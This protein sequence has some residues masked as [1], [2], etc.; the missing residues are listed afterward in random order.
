LVRWV[1]IAA[2]VAA[3][4]FAYIK[5]YKKSHG[6]NKLYLNTINSILIAAAVL[7]LCIALLFAKT[8]IDY[9][10]RY[11]TIGFPL[12]VLLWLLLNVYTN[13][14][15]IIIAATFVSFYILILAFNYK[16]P[17]ND[18][19][20]R[21]LAAYVSRIEKPNEPILFYPKVLALPFKYYYNGKNVIGPLPDEI[22]FDTTYLSKIQDTVQLQRAIDKA[23]TSSGSYILITNRNDSRFENEA[24]VILLNKYLPVHY[25]IISD[26]FFTGKYNPLRVRRL[27]KKE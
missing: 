15:K 6:T 25:N 21:A 19:N 17:V 22:K 26:T 11:L 27:S 23:G 7:V 3:L 10:D 1:V 4:G 5:L 2:F 18:F 12:M 8:G 13:T 24:D 14:I 16:Q 20:S 9:N